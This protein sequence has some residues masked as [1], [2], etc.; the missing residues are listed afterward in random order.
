MHILLAAALVALVVRVVVP[1]TRTVVY[2][3]RTHHIT[4]PAPEECPRCAE[5]D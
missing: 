5:V 2:K 4:I 1:P 3:C